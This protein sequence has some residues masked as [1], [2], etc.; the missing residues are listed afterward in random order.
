LSL[1]T[2][3]K[4]GRLASQS[5]AGRDKELIGVLLISNVLFNIADLSTTVL[6]LGKGLQEGNLVLLVI[7]AALG[8]SILASLLVMK[9][10]I[11]TVAAIVALVGV[12]SPSGAGRHLALC[13]LLAS[14]SLFCIISLNNVFWIIS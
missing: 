12:R 11:V 2:R 1:I 14:T 4:I 6:A 3:Y 8:L 7:S 13:Y 9:V 10:L 5:L